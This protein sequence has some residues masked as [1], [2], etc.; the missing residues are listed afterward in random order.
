MENQAILLLCE[1]NYAALRAAINFPKENLLLRGAPKIFGG[2][3][4]CCD[5]AIKFSSEN[6]PR[7]G[8]RSMA[9]APIRSVYT[10]FS[11][12]CVVVIKYKICCVVVIK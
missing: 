12:A 9:S 2:K 4:Y 10:F 11:N 8:S 1:M 7:P 3:F 6:F 5:A